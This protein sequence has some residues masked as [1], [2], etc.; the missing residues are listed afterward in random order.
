M[1]HH[2]FDQIINIQGE[3]FREQKN[4]KTLKFI[5]NSQAYFIKIHLG[6]GLKEILKNLFQLKTPV[7]GAANEVNALIKLKNTGFV[8]II[9][10]YGFKGINPA[11]LKSYIITKA[12]E[13]TITLED[14]CQHWSIHPPPLRLK[15]QLIQKV[16]SIAKTIHDAGVNHRDFYI[17]HFLLHQKNI[18]KLELTVIDWHRAQIRKKVPLRWRI[19]DISGLYFSALDC[20]LTKKDLLLFQK[21]YQYQHPSFWKDVEKKALKLYHKV[22]EKKHDVFAK[23]GYDDNTG[24]TR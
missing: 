16:A 23:K 8:P 22:R 5:E 15:R 2:Q 9:A 11:K 17:C 3:V 19:K 20:G 21:T 6:P 4:R 18:E 13:N 1:Q 12:I 10:G 7:L 24:A 14:F